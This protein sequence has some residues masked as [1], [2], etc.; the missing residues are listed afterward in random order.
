M[1]NIS[2]RLVEKHK[3]KLGLTFIRGSGVQ[4]AVP[5]NKSHDRELEKTAEENAS[6]CLT[7]T[8]AMKE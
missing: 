4:I 2:V 5:S 1:Y 8:M 7:G 6:A 3:E